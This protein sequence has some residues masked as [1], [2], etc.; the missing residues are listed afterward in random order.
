MP[1][2][3]Y[4]LG[5]PAHFWVAVMSRHDPAP[6]TA[7]AASTAVV[8]VRDHDVGAHGPQKAFLR[9]RRGG[10]DK[11][12]QVPDFYIG[13]HAAIAG[14]RLLTRDVRRYRSYFP[15]IEII[16]PTPAEDETTQ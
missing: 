14:Y 12:S 15:T 7:A 8:P 9:Y 13:A 3:H 11:R 1:L 5:R 6:A 16:A 4:Y 2:V 10:G